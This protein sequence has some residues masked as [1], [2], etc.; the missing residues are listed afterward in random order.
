[1]SIAEKLTTIAEN[2]PKVYEAGK[3]SGMG[4]YEQGFNDGKNSVINLG[5]LCQTI[6]FEN[7]NVF[8]KSEVELN[9]QNC[10]DLRGLCSPKIAQNKNVTVERLVIN[11]NSPTNINGMLSANF[12]NARDYTLKHLTFNVN[13]ANTTDVG[14]AF[15]G[16][17]ALE[18]IDGTPLDFSSVVTD[19]TISNVFHSCNALV[20]VRFVPLT[21]KR[22]FNLQ[23]SSRLS[24][25]SIQSIIDGLADLTGQTTQTL[26][27][28]SDIVVKLTDEQMLQIIN[29]NWEVM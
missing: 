13:T 5:E 14:Y 22:K 20:E 8:G 15:Y 4:G 12:N 10:T 16:M 19:V 6:Q 27:F 11:C 25:E 2:I 18:I 17:S 28:Y 26:Y 21:I 29:K 1:M 3:A 7:F 24:A 9:L 23:H